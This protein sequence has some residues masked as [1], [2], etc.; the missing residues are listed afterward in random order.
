MVNCVDHDLVVEIKLSR[1]IQ[2]TVGALKA[3]KVY[4]NKENYQNLKH[5]DSRNLGLISAHIDYCEGGLCH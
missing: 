4:D 3:T 5:K 1:N 2:Y